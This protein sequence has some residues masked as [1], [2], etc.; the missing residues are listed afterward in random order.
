M[1]CKPESLPHSIE[2]IKKLPVTKKIKNIFTVQGMNR[3][4]IFHPITRRMRVH[5]FMMHAGAL[6]LSLLVS[7]AAC[8]GNTRY[9]TLK[10]FHKKKTFGASMDRP[11]QSR[12]GATPEFLLQYIRDLDKNP[13]YWDYRLDERGRKTV[14]SALYS[15]PGYLRE[16]L[17]DRLLGIY[18]IEGLAGSGVTEWVS[19][20]DGKIYAFML[21]NPRILDMDMPY[22][23]TWKE[24]T[25]F[26]NDDPRMRIR[27]SCGEGMDG[28]FYILLHESLHVYDYA[29]RVT[30]YCDDGI[31]EYQNLGTGHSSFTKGLWCDY[32]A[33]CS[34]PW[35]HGKVRFYGLGGPG[36]L[37][38]SKAR[39]VYESLSQGP[40]LSI[41]STQSWAEDVAELATF[42]HLTEVLHYPY[43]IDV[44]K[45]GTVLGSY[46][47]GEF[48]K[49]K[50]RFGMI[51]G[52]YKNE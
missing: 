39:E 9:H 20:E 33:P 21:Y 19:D 16:T 3:S 27:I 7:S 4:D 24:N 47:P 14:E 26:N 23:L 17:T 5:C 6:L 18:F 13:G 32:A 40:F 52:L 10:D 49:V 38:I 34:R 36:L 37:P 25:A 50:E 46:H 48:P 28:F 12:I 8:A 43:R 45:D 41:Y 42:Y 51:R 31:R 2:Y 15:L 44:L 30:P 35:F 11:L 29:H 1:I 22:L